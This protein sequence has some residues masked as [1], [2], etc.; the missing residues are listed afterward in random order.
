MNA[1]F[2][3]PPLAIL[4]VQQS[5]ID[6]SLVSVLTPLPQHAS[7]VR[8]TSRNLRFSVGTNPARKM[9]MPGK[10]LS[11]NAMGAQITCT[12]SDREWKSYNSIGSRSA[13]QAA[14]KVREVIQNSKIM[15]DNNDKAAAVSH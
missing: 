12:F 3:M 4:L 13:V 9:L 14:Y 7:K 6:V 5:V 2:P 15:F 11:K 1:S 8:D 10:N